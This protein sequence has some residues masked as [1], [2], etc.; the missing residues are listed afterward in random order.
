MLGSEAMQK[1]LNEAAERHRAQVPRDH[2]GPAM[3]EVGPDS[4]IYSIEGF[5]PVWEPKAENF[6][7]YDEDE[8]DWRDLDVEEETARLA[9]P[10]E[11]KCEVPE[12]ATGA[13][14]SPLADQTPRSS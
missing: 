6:V 4:D 1:T 8:P 11:T 7:P 5:E 12:A 9:P 10:N 14:P 2:P 3:L 13:E